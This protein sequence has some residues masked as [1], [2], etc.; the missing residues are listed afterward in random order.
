MLPVDTMSL[1]FPEIS[2]SCVSVPTILVIR[3]FVLLVHHFYDTI[4]KPS[5]C[6]SSNYD[7]HIQT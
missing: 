7:S 1:E 2:I 3:Y 5:V 6:V 4:G